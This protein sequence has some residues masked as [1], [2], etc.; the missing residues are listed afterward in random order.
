MTCPR[1]DS[2]RVSFLLRSA[3]GVGT[4]GP[5]NQCPVPPIFVE[6]SGSHVLESPEGLVKTQLTGP[7]PRVSDSVVLGSGLRI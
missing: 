7:H 3:I 6:S 5:S 2:V 1:Y 4:H